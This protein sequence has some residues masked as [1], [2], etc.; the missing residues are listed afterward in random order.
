MRVSL[1]NYEAASSENPTVMEFLSTLS[2][3]APRTI[4]FI[5]KAS[6]EKWTVALIRHK[7]IQ[8]HF[9]QQPQYVV[10]IA[11][12]RQFEVDNEDESDIGTVISVCVDSK[13]QHTEVEV[14]N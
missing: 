2:M 7:E 10:T 14:R 11:T 9:F 3:S 5:S 1:N 8:T 4:S 6:D 12:V 13:E